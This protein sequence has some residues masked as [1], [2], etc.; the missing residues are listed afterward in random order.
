M[1]H[2]I[3]PVLLLVLFAAACGDEEKESAQTIAPTSPVAGS[4]TATPGG[5]APPG[6]QAIVDAALSGDP[7]ELRALIGYTAVACVRE[8]VGMGGPPLCRDGE[9]E[10]T[11]VD[12]LWV[13]GCEGE[14]RRSDELDEIPLSQ[15]SAL[16]FYAAY[17][18]PE[19]FN[20]PPVA[21]EYAAIFSRTG[22]TAETLAVA[23]LIE[24]GEL[25]A[26]KLG[27]GESPKGLVESDQ[28]EEVVLPPPGP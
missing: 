13:A 19:E 28:L 8:P 12:V 1:R 26:I 20:A 2:A 25:V 15:L 9:A 5:A 7:Q 11:P 10:G 27:C 24:G 23:L 18:W 4:T 17:R 14:Y 22:P 21:A 6:I 3:L 16:D